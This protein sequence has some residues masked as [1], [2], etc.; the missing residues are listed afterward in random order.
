MDPPLL[1]FIILADNAITDV[2][3]DINELDVFEE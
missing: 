3:S 1:L 2:L